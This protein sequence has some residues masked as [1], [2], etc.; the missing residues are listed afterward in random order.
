MNLSQRQTIREVIEATRIHKAVIRNSLKRKLIIP[1]ETL[2]DLEEGM[3][4]SISKL[5]QIVG[6]DYE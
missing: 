1:K 2:K 6:D 5:S 3:D 4:I